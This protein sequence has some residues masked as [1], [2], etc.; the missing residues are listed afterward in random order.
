MTN[1]SSQHQQRRPEDDNLLTSEEYKKYLEILKDTETT[2]AGRL[3]DWQVNFSQ[4][5]LEKF[6]RYEKTVRC[7]PKQK[8]ML[9]KI[10]KAMYGI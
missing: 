8:E 3:T 7:S 1:G 2:Y 6:T 5:M 9:D 10:E 4:D